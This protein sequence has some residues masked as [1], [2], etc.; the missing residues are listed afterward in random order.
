MSRRDFARD[1]LNEQTPKSWVINRLACLCE[2]CMD[3]GPAVTNDDE[4]WGGLSLCRERGYIGAV[5]GQVTEYSCA[6]SILSKKSPT[7]RPCNSRRISNIVNH[8]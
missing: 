7:G 2:Y 8:R 4:L 3:E 6:A 5:M 1:V